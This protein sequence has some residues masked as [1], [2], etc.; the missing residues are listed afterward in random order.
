VNDDATE[1]PERGAI[2]HAIGKRCSLEDGVEIALLVQE[3]RHVAANL[4]A[5]PEY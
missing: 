3:P 4:A 2:A 1:L 5:I